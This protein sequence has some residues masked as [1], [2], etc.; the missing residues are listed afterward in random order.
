MLRLASKMSVNLVWQTAI[1][2]FTSKRFRS[3]CVVV[4][5]L[6]LAAAAE[7]GAHRGRLALD[8]DVDAFGHVGR[9]DVVAAARLRAHPARR[10]HIGQRVHRTVAARQTRTH[11]PHTT[12]VPYLLDTDGRRS[13]WMILDAFG[14]SGKKG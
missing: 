10:T 8:A 6:S 12:V 2:D 1:A 14:G 9:P 13:S 11:D 5:D 3:L 4:T 7:L